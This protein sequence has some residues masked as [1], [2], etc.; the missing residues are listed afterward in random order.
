MVKLVVVNSLSGVV[1]EYGLLG[2]VVLG[3]KR[4]YLGLGEKDDGGKEIGG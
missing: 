3:I 2:E 4:F 1:S